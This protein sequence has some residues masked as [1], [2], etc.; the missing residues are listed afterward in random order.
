MIYIILCSIIFVGL[1]VWIDAEHLN[2]HQYIGDHT[3]RS[4]LR[5]FVF[6]LIGGSIA[7]FA[8]SGAIFFL[9]FDIC[10]NYATDNYWNYIGGTASIDKF[11][12]KYPRWWF[13]AKLIVL[14][15]SI[16]L[17]ILI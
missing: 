10:L 5:L 14:T 11:F 17:T 16:L 6:A 3:S 2:K 15:L 12:R 1:S 13:P 4:V 7:G 8:L 9:L